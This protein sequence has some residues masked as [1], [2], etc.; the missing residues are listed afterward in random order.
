MIEFEDPKKIMKIK[1]LRPRFF[2]D[3]ISGKRISRDSGE[4]IQI[5]AMDAKPLIAANMATENLDVHIEARYKKI[6]K[7][8]S[9][10]KEA[11]NAEIADLKSQIMLL[12]SEIRSLRNTPTTRPVGRPPKSNSMMED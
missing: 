4:I 1:L 8:N 6:K 12:N 2:I 7:S 5:P 9:N 10:N 3:A 11:I